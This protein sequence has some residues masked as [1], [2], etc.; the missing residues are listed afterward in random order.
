MIVAFARALV[1]RAADWQFDVPAPGEHRIGAKIN[2]DVAKQHRRAVMG[3]EPHARHPVLD[4]K[5]HRHRGTG[6]EFP[7]SPASGE[8]IERKGLREIHHGYDRPAI[9]S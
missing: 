7:M 2:I 5:G 1:E 3:F 4:R 8:R 6:P 9:G